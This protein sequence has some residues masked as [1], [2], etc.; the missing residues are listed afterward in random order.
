MQ[1]T[2]KYH[3]N[4]IDT[5]DPFG[6]EA[7]NGNAQKLETA[8]NQHE[9]AVDAALASHKSATDAALASQKR[10]WQAADTALSQNITAV[11]TRVTAVETA[12]N[13]V[14]LGYAVTTVN[15]QALTFNRSGVNMN[16][17]ACLL[18]LCTGGGNVSRTLSVNGTKVTVILNF[19]SGMGSSLTILQPFQSYVISLSC[20][21]TGNSN[22]TSFIRPSSITQSWAGIT[23]LT[24][25]GNDASGSTLAIYALKK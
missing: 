10:E 24:V 6:P 16:S 5:S 8:L 25:T 11:N 7:L 13:I 23:N 21:G 14:R 19:S 9:A 3:F 12:A 1:Q 18:I 17:Y 4:L 15:D 22:T 20:I 2:N